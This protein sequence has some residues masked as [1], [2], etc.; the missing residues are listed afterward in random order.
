MKFEWDK[1]NVEKIENRHEINPA[2]SEEVFFNMLLMLK[3]DIKHSRSEARYQAMG[4]TNTK[5]LLFIVF[6]IHNKKIRVI[7]A[8]D[9]SRKERRAYHEA[10]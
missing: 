4:K 7:T 9:A 3:P 10:A 8:R 6:T 2:E 1:H 5:R